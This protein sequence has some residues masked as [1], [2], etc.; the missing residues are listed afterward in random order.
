MNWFKA[1]NIVSLVLLLAGCHPQPVST[2]MDTPQRL[3]DDYEGSIRGI[4]IKPG[5]GKD[6]SVCFVKKDGALVCHAAGKTSPDVAAWR[7]LG[8]LNDISGP[9]AVNETGSIACTLSADAPKRVMPLANQM[10]LRINFLGGSEFCALINNAHGNYAKCYDATEERAVA[11]AQMMTVNNPDGTT[12]PKIDH[13]ISVEHARENGTGDR[14]ACGVR[15]SGK[16]WCYNLTAKTELPLANTTLSRSLAIHNTLRCSASVSG[17][18]SCEKLKGGVT[19]LPGAL[20]ITNVVEVTGKDQRMCARYADGDFA[21]W[22]GM[23]VYNRRRFNTFQKAVKVQPSQHG[24]CAVFADEKTRCLEPVSGSLIAYQELQADAI[25]A[26]GDQT[27]ST[28]ADGKFNCWGKTRSYNVPGNLPFPTGQEVAVGS[29]HLCYTDDGV[30]HCEGDND[31][32]QLQVPAALGTDV[33]QVVASNKHTCALTQ[34]QKVFCWGENIAGETV[35]PADLGPVKSIATG[36]AL[37]CA[38]GAADQLRCWGDSILVAEV[39]KVKKVAEVAIGH[40]HFCVLDQDQQ[41]SCFGSRGEGKL[42]P[43]P[44]PNGFVQLKAGANHTCAVDALSAAPYC[45]G[46]NSEGQTEIPASLEK[47]TKLALGDNHSCATDS[48]NKVVCWGLDLASDINGRH[49]VASGAPRQK[50]RGGLFRHVSFKEPLALCNGSA[51]NLP[52]EPLALLRGVF[53]RIL[54]PLT[55]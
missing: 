53:S 18:L 21:C 15:T 3:K 42:I 26:S 40:T 47:A 44:S 31:K 34:N 48:K 49:E 20:R 2:V 24:I 52:Q 9:C 41:P 22:E 12:T 28:T 8:Q 19:S 4:D 23:Q 29:D 36:R 50:Y 27:C 11:M 7:V 30:V 10:V 39:R 45:W 46:S 35:V 17:Q 14:M 38:I 16:S 55:L 51:C 33:T 37:T 13:V 54:E 5:A 25:M 6:P 43:F 1:G 32:N